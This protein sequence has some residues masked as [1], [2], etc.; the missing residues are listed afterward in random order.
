MAENQELQNKM[1]KMQ[2]MMKESKKQGSSI[3]IMIA[4]LGS[5]ALQS[6]AGVTLPPEILATLASGIGALGGRIQSRIE[7][8][9]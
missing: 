6:Q 3:G 1:S 5:Y 4:V 7:N 2:R 9:G 8:L